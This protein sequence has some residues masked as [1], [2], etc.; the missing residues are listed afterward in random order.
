MP[1]LEDQLTIKR[2]TI[3]G[4]GKGLFTR[5]F[6]AKGT[7]IVQ[8]KGY[9]T[10]WKAVQQR[11]DFNGYVYYI[12]RNTVIDAKN[13]VTTFARYANDANGLT[14]IKNVKNNCTYIVEGNRVFVE[15]L[16]DI[17]PGEEL[18]VSYGRAYWEVIRY[19][20]KLSV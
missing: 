15:A 4:A 19:N 12:N 17:H 18:F 20:M 10:T 9:T 8:Y 3:P 6:I 1:L 5:K 7:R 16:K 11:K 2:S 13:Y 14:R